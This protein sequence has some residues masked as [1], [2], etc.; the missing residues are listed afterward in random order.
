MNGN[1]DSVLLETIV[2]I[3]IIRFISF[4]SNEIDDVV[5]NKSS[6]KIQKHGVFGT[7]KNRYKN[8][9]EILTVNTFQFTVCLIVL[10]IYYNSA[11]YKLNEVVYKCVLFAL[12]FLFK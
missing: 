10:R 1:I 6:E 4:N 11:L 7:K 3:I 5:T 9:I 12:S 8:Q 2:Y